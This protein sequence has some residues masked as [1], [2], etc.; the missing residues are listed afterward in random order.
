MR[1]VRTTK[2]MMMKMIFDNITNHYKNVRNNAGQK[3][4]Y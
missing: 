2:M 4:H 3:F 1:V